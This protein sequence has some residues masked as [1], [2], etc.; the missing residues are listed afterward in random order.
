[1]DCTKFAR[2]VAVAV[3]RWPP[4]WRVLRGPLRRMFDGLAPTWDTR[5]SELHMAPLEAALDR[6]GAATRILDVGTGTG[7]AARLLAARWPGAEVTGVDLSTEMVREAQG[8]AVS[9]RERYLAVDAAALPFD[10]G[11][12]DLVYSSS[13]IEHIAPER[14]QA[15]SDEIRRVG[16]GWFVQTPAYSFPIEPHALLPFAHW[17]PTSLRR[18][19]WRL[20]A[21]GDWEDIHL[22]RR[23]ELAGLFPDGAI[24]AER[25]IGVAKSWVA[26]RAPLV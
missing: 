15:F 6:V 24:R 3:V 16:R 9:G 11:A 14:R 4:L 19:Y 1:M 20:G 7:A 18:R 10:D 12:F 21:A 2:F 13:V 5:V 25:F 23:G 17:L 26:V 8:R 22:L